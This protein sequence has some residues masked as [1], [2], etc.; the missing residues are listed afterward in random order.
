MTDWRAIAHEHYPDWGDDDSAISAE[1]IIRLDALGVRHSPAADWDRGPYQPLEA[2]GI[3]LPVLALVVYDPQ[4]LPQDREW[5]AAKNFSDGIFCSHNADILTIL[6]PR[7]PEG[8]AQLAAAYHR[9]NIAFADLNQTIEYRDRLR[10]F[11][12]ADCAVSYRWW[13]EARFPIDLDC[14]AALTDEQ[15]AIPEADD[16]RLLVIAAN[17]DDREPELEP[18]YEP[19]PASFEFGPFVT[20][21]EYQRQVADQEEPE[22]RPVTEA[23]LTLPV[24]VL[25]TYGDLDDSV[26]REHTWYAIDHD[27]ERFATV[28]GPLPALAEGVATLAAEFSGSVPDDDEIPFDRILAYRARLKELLGADCVQSFRGFS[29]SVCPIDLEFLEALT[30]RPLAAYTDDPGSWEIM[31]LV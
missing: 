9:S 30:G 14:L 23:G 19:A 11:L 16:V 3:E 6:R 15:V 2:Y 25:A 10:E 5:L 18:A 26:S 4:E 7:S 29:P 24:L 12:G 20:I 13:S 17:S 8:L 28:L 31:L 1:E 22:H 27:R 21:A